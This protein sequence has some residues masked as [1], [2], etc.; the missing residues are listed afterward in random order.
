MQSEECSLIPKQMLAKI[1][2][3]CESQ[4]WPFI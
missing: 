1:C 2:F 3:V 4:A